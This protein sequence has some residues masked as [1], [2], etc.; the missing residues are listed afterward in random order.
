VTSAA[1]IGSGRVFRPIRKNGAVWGEG[2][3]EIL[4]WHVVNRYCRS[5]GL[6]HAAPHDLRR[7]APSCATPAAANWNGF[8]SCSA[9]S[10]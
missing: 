3:S 9:M 6:E 7:T 1:K 8:S 4:V 10:Q 5:L 2:I